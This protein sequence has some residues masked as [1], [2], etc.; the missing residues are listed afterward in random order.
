MSQRIDEP[1][2][3]VDQGR[4]FLI[5][6]I[7]QCERVLEVLRKRKRGE[8]PRDLDGMIVR[9]LIRQLVQGWV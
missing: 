1:G 3:A 4:A 6:D 9:Q 5:A 8:A 2:N 7:V